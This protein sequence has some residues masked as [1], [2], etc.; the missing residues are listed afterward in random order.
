MSEE[1]KFLNYYK[2][3]LLFLRNKGGAFAKRHPDI[4]E[5]LDLKDGESSDPHTERIIESVAF[6]SA[7]LSQKIDDNAQY[8]AFHLLDSLYPSLINTFPP[9]GIVKYSQKSSAAVV[10]KIHIPKSTKLS[11]D[12]RE[13]TSCTFQTVYPLDIYPISI[14]DVHIE[15][16]LKKIRNSDDHCIEIGIKTDSVPIE[17]LNIQT[18]LFSINSDIIEDALLIYEAIFSNTMGKIILNVKGHH[19][20]IDRKNIV[21]CGFFDDEAVCPVPKY[22]NN[23]FQLFQEMLH[24]KRKF[25]FFKILD[26]GRVINDTHINDIDEF[27][28]LIEISLIHDRLS[29]IVKKDSIVINTVPIVNLFPVTSDPFRFDGTKNRYLLVADQSR[30]SSLEIQSILSIHML[31][32]HIKEDMI[33]QPYFALNIDSDDN[34]IHDIYWTYSREPVETK[35]LGGHDTYLSFIETN[36]NPE[37]SYPNVVYAQTLCT[38]RFT[39]RDIPTLTTIHTENIEIGNYVARL[40]H[41]MTKPISMSE[42][43]N[44]LWKLVSHLATTHI[45]L[46]NEESLLSGI[47]KLIAIFAEENEMSVHRILNQIKQIKTGRI[48]RRIGTDAWRGFVTGIEVM[49]HISDEEYSHHIFLLCCVLNQFLSSC[50]S[51]NSFIELRLISDANNKILSKWPPTSGRKELV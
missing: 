37:S 42:E 40:S 1:K 9:C 50:I 4:A 31:D 23:V 34:I 30:H 41:K 45:S 16:M 11:C 19:I 43:S 10:D 35:E 29:E 15:Q 7:R 27:S 18:L 21:P 26:L 36:L 3:E 25:M 6:L 47:S 51:I 14:T 8:I 24:F 39:T 33:I 13:G 17:K 44:T 49:V 5:K 38:N 12:S 2:D 20:T 48:V 32:Q 28:I 22:S 46:A